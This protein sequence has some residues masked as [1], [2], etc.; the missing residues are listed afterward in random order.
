ML[1]VFTSDKLLRSGL[2][3][4]TDRGKQMSEIDNCKAHRQSF[5]PKDAW[6]PQT[7][8][9]QSDEE[10]LARKFQDSQKDEQLSFLICIDGLKKTARC[11]VPGEAK[12]FK[13]RLIPISACSVLV[14]LKQFIFLLLT[15]APFS[16]CGNVI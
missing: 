3:T 9:I 14:K 13:C 2:I 15:M 11:A 16:D 1:T 7:T 5:Q 12:M 6:T 8:Q 10:R 4:I